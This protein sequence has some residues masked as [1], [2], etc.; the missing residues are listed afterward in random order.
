MLIEE[1]AI[2]NKSKAEGEHINKQVEHSRKHN[3]WNKQ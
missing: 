1:K 3:E 2:D